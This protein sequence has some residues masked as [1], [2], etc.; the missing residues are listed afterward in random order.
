MTED[1]ELSCR[2]GELHG[3]LRG[4]APKVVNRAL[5]YCDD[6]Q[7]FLHY[8]NRADLLD[9]H[10]GSDIVQVA[11][12]MVTFDRGRERIAC[13]RLSPKGMHRWYASCCKTPLGNTLTPAVA[14]IGMG[15]ELF[16]GTP[17]A[18]SRDER[19][20]KIRFA[21][22]PQFAIGGFPGGVPK[23]HLGHFVVMVGR[24]IGWRLKGGAWP[25]PFFDR[26]T[27]APCCPVTILTKAERDA[28]RPKCGPHP[29]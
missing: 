5:C 3:T 20:G 9:A 25:H 11:P 23:A 7:A 6:C 27:H 8:L 14:F 13:V 19:F 1:V 24:V 16:R 22:F 2:C 26:R 12:S 10:G 15:M 4:A 21:S 18:H 17:D 28:L 29:R